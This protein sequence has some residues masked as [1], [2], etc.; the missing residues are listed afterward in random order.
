MRVRFGNL[1]RYQGKIFSF[2]GRYAVN[3]ITQHFNSI[4]PGP[5]QHLGGLTFVPLQAEAKTDISHIKT[6]DDLATQ[7]LAAPSEHQS[8]PV[9]TSI[10]I[11]NNNN[12]LLVLSIRLSLASLLPFIHMSNGPTLAPLNLSSV[13]FSTMEC[14][15]MGNL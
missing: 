6:F 2:F 11:K 13:F 10:D 3:A 9:V 1:S 7:N 12:N 15:K 5:A 8:E 14:I 4:E